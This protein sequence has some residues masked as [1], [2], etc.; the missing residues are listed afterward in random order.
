MLDS[1]LVIVESPFQGQH[2][3]NNIYLS[4]AIADCFSRGEVPFAS[5]GFYTRY[6]DDSKPEDR[7][8]GIEAG[9]NIMSRADYVAVY[10]DYGMS[11]GMIAAIQ[12]AKAYGLPV[13]KRTIKINEET[14]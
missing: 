6:L 13:K 5:H 14:E 8:M 1:P 10:V 9:Y 3:R 12:K 4:R 2:V 11:T 7:K